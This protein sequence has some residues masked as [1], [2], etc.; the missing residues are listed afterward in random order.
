[1]LESDGLNFRPKNL[2]RDARF[3]FGLY[4]AALALIAFWP[5]P[6]D[7][8]MH[9]WIK[10][11]MSIAPALHYTQIEFLS[12]VVLFAHFGLLLGMILRARYLVL[13]LAI[14]TTTTIEFVQWLCLPQR[15]PSVWDL[16]ANASGACLGIVV[17][18]LVKR[19]P[20]KG[21]ENV[22]TPRE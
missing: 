11:I 6:V 19:V 8:G 10:F 2:I 15:T 9:D 18:E 17:A 7:R 22:T 16:W 5:V 20:K 14:I 3:Y 4:L 13:P 1:L 12:N 21:K